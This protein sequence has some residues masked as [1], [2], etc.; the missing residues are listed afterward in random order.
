M[1]ETDSTTR[2]VSV[3]LAVMAL[4]VALFA[5]VAFTLGPLLE[6]DPDLSEI[7]HTIALVL[8]VTGAIQGGLAYRHLT[9]RLAAEGSADARAM[10][11]R[12]RAITVIAGAEA[13]ALAALLAVLLFG[14]SWH[15]APGLVL[16]V[17]ALALVWPT[18]GR[19]AHEVEGSERDKYG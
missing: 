16:F 2:G 12:T 17:V 13:A 15:A 5:G 7:V 10:Q 19:I 14:A 1:S 3:L 6:P 11:F 4:G 8:A 18:A 9:R